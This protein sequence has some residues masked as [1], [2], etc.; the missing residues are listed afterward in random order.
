[1][2]R[3]FLST[4]F[5]LCAAALSVTAQ[6]VNERA[7]NYPV[8]AAQQNNRRIEPKPKVEGWAAQRVEENLNRG[9]AALP[10]G[11]G[12][13]YVSWRLLKSDPQDVAFNLYRS[14][15]G[16]KFQKVNA[17]PLTKTTDYTDVKANPSKKNAYMVRPVVG[18]KEQAASEQA[19]ASDKNYTSIK[20]QGDYVIQK[21]AL[22]D[23]NGDGVYDYI[24]KQPNQTVDPG[25]WRRSETTWKIEAYLSDGTFLWR[26]DLGWNIEQGVWYS[27]MVAYDLNGDGKA[28][29]AV[30]TAPTDKDYR[31]KAG[32]VVG[33]PPYYYGDEPL[34]K[35]LQPCPEFCSILDGMTGEVIDS[36][37]WPPQ[38]QRVG[39]YVR[40]NRN[41]IGVAYLDG[42]T[43]CLL[44][45]RG[46]YRAMLLDAYQLKNNKLEKL[47][48]WD[49]DEEN[50]AVRSQ[51]AHQMVS[52]DV[53]G[54]GREEVV[55]GSVVVDDNGECLWSVGLGHPDKAYV[56]DVDPTR[57]GLEIFYALEVW[58]EKNGVALVDA[59]TGE[60]IW[61]INHPTTHVGD[62][63]A[64]DID[65]ALPGL[66]CF[67]HEAKKAGSED[68]YMFNAQGQRLAS[69]AEVPGCREWVW[70]DADLLR[71]TTERPDKGP[72]N[73]VK[74]KGETLTEGL[75]GQI[76]MIAD[77]K[78][79]W[80]EEIV[81]MLPGELRIYS[82]TIP[83]ADRRTTLMQDALYR[84]YVAHRSMGY[85]QPPTVGYYLGVAPEDAA[86][87]T[88]ILKKR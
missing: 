16:G 78:G 4:A 53:D 77:L 42:K 54:D 79:D 80:R 36:C 6:D 64:V 32:R 67:A 2:N 44:L 50:P 71:E 41:Q 26:K 49:G 35:S 11:Q 48:S 14:V 34:D 45:N 33:T 75:E 63:V 76:M 9:V 10:N 22:A 81:T 56:A 52:A 23:L 1:M 8:L 84:S 88:P 83:A 46:T 86:K 39:D 12:Q 87:H 66:E 18:G 47:W 19:I 69:A 82:T 60:F 85:D 24:I 30:K 7:Y 43:P 38:S 15:D 57:P 17:K 20:F 27:P 51:G 37:P 74:Y 55:L 31:D 29:I 61:S 21:V 73:M 28:E 13:I 40:T 68:K 59:K 62:G 65:P 70:W 5:V 58:H 3:K 72:F 25:V